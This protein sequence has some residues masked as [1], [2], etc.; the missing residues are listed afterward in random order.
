[1]KGN[2]ILILLTS[3][4]LIIILV[5]NSSYKYK[6]NILYSQNDITGYEEKV[7]DNSTNLINRKQAINMATYIIEEVFEIDINNDN[8]QMFVDLYR[9]TRSECY[10]WDI[11]WSKNDSSGGYEVEIDS[12]IGDIEYIYIDEVLNS[13]NTNKE[14]SE[15]EVKHILNEFALKIDMNINSYNLKISNRSD[16]DYA[17]NKT[18][19]K[20]CLLTSKID[21]QNTIEILI[22]CRTKSI[23]KYTKNSV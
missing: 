2:I 6:E 9:D 22:N 20:V 10:K 13:N 23:V 17:N 8:S 4:I 1:M 7:E 16:Y 3:L 12:N 18:N 5:C 15:D 14:I 21:P 11:F 19:Y